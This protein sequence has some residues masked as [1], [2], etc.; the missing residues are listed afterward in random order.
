MLIYSNSPKE[1]TDKSNLVSQ[2]SAC[3]WSAVSERVIQNR[4]PENPSLV[5]FDCAHAFTFNNGFWT[6]VEK[7]TSVSIG[8]NQK[9]WGLWEQEWAR[10]DQK[11]KLYLEMELN[12]WLFL[13]PVNFLPKSCI[14]YPGNPYLALLASEPLI[15]GPFGLSH[16]TSKVMQCIHLLHI[17]H[18]CMLL[19]IF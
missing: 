3:L 19:R 7:V 5:C 17:L 8:L 13:D 10:M 12:N 4:D 14:L 11:V 9:D 6:R 16:V 1:I 2:E 18:L 15:K